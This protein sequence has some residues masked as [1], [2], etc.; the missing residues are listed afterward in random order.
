MRGI[1]NA[2][3]MQPIYTLRYRIQNACV[4]VE[5]RYAIGVFQRHCISKQKDPVYR[6]LPCR[7]RSSGRTYYLW[8]DCNSNWMEP[9][10][11]GVSDAH[12]RPKTSD[13]PVLP[14]SNGNISDDEEEIDGHSS[15]LV[16]LNNRIKNDFMSYCLSFLH[17]DV[18]A[19]E[20]VH[21]VWNKYLQCVGDV[22][23]VSRSERAKWSS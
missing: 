11:N 23:T 10:V 20:C 17:E 22:S 12:V 19:R 15:H 16:E 21:A 3:G 1:C 13:S 8:F 9:K 6:F 2:I 7:F 5:R 14:V 4:T 18:E